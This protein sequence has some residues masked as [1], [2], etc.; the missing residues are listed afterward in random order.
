MSNGA[1]PFVRWQ[2]LLLTI[3]A[4]GCLLAAQRP[5]GAAEAERIPQCGVASLYA[6]MRTLKRDVSLDELQQQFQQQLRRVDL[7]TVSL[8]EIRQVAES[9][10]LHTAMLRAEPGDL[11]SISLPA[12]LYLRI[13]HRTGPSANVGHFV[14][15][16]ATYGEQAEVIDLTATH[17]WRWI[18][19]SRLREF[20]QGELLAVSTK[21]V[22]V[23]SPWLRH[24]AAWLFFGSAFATALLA[25]RLFSTRLKERSEVSNVVQPAA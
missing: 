18:P 14:V 11:P 8:A 24:A 1:E 25:W 2:S 3:L 5:S 20:W 23:P 15:V 19:I 4:V 10:R 12:I 16:R 21:P 13:P 9:Y 6:T 22:V 7:T 17:G